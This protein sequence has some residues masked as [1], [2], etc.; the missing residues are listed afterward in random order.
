MTTQR[1]GD[2]G[3]NNSRGSVAGAGWRCPARDLKALLPAERRGKPPFRW[4]NLGTLLESRNDQLAKW[5]GDPSPEQRQLWLRDRYGD[6]SP[7]LRLDRTDL[8]EPSLLLVGD[9]GEG[10]ASQYALLALLEHLGQ[11]SDFMVICSDVIYP[12]GEVEQ[13][14]H[15]FFHPYRGY[16]APIY[17]LPG[18]H[19]W[20]D[21][22]RGFMFHFCGRDRQPK[23][24]KPSLLSRARLRERLWRRNPR[25]PDPARVER[26]R[27]L[28]SHPE[29]QA[30]LPGPYYV[31]D[32]GPIELVAID[33]G[34]VSGIDC[35]QGEW[36]RR[37]SRSPKPKI[38][39]TGKPIYV[40]AK[41][42]P[43]EIDGGRGGTVD[44]IVRDPDC[45]YIAAIGGDIHNYQR[46]TVDVDGRALQY[47][48]TGGGGA[49]MHATHKIPNIDKSDLQGVRETNFRCYPLRGDS[50]SFYSLLY[51]RKFP[52]SWAIDPDQAAAYMSERLAIE[53]TKDDAKGVKVSDETRRKARRVFPLPGRGRGPLHSWFSEFFDWNEPPLFKNALRIDATGDRVTITCHAATGCVED[54]LR[55]PEDQLVCE[56]HADGSWRWQN[57]P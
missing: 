26:M 45:N 20:Y 27:A 2:Q 1:P 56:R 43:C 17:A 35:V 42:R 24:P 3:A 48:V 52:G 22:L 49:F 47:I 40:D 6:S 57:D 10:D 8:S 16:L 19:D 23:R 41:H 4:S 13:Y 34:I 18:N 55:E 38:L 46:Y 15:K 25:S 21:D 28:R 29:Q 7:D 37:V 9:T 51:D 30:S 33:T 44:A 32:T 5:L 53:A 14:E 54:H 12:G 36:L 11:D 50:L 31:I 39:L